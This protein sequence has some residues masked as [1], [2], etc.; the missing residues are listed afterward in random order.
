V[1]SLVE[2]HERK[3]QQTIAYLKAGKTAEAESMACALLNEDTHDPYALFLAGMCQLQAGRSGLSYHL[4]ARACEYEEKPEILNN[5]VH[6]LN[7]TAYWEEALGLCQKAL[8]HGDV[9]KALEMV[10]QAALAKD[11]G[12]IK[13]LKHQIES[14]ATTYSNM[15]S[16]YADMG[17]VDECLD[18]ADTAL[19]ILPDYKNAKWN[20]ALAHLKRRNW[21]QGFK[22]YDEALGSD[23]RPIKTYDS[24]NQPFWDGKGGVPI[25]YS[26]QGIGDEIMWASMIPDAI[27]SAEHVIIDCE[28]RLVGLLRRSFPEAT[29]ST[30]GRK[31]GLPLPEGTP[32]ATHR[33]GL[34]SLGHLFRNKDEDFPSRPYLVADHERRIQWKALLNSVAKSGRLK[35]GFNWRGGIPKT[36]EARRSLGLDD[37]APLM[38]V[39]GEWISLNHRPDA[40][41]E[42]EEFTKRTGR[43]IHHWDRMHGADF[44][45]TAAAIA[46]CDLVIS[47]TTT[48]I[49]AA[50]A[51]GVPCFVLV[52]ENP[53]WRYMETGDRMPWYGSVRLF[54][55]KDGEWPIRDVAERLRQRIEFRRAS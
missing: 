21:R 23:H 33:I 52:P 19:K 8:A 18:A 45:D 36:G 37:F 30:S 1:A 38:S 29:V 5:M 15:A 12:E 2:K 20:A 40:G 27:R 11:N 26:E 53:T 31:N 6:G 28:P 4:F 46:E 47:V 25:I 10:S 50:G 54:R 7:G 49:H 22:W 48:V 35:I 14:I 17:K 13:V 39:G 51:L 16:I 43:K 32:K 42:I 44:D 41:D 9:T 55:Q 24:P 3:L 34:G